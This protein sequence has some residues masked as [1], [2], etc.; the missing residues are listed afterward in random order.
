MIKVFVTG[1]GGTVGI[2]VIKALNLEREKFKIIASDM[3]PASAGLYFKKIFLID[4][5]YCVPPVIDK[6]YLSLL[7]NI[8]E[9]EKIDIIIPTSPPE[10]LFFAKNEDSFSSRGIKIAAPNKE[11]IYKLSDKW[12]S[13][14]LLN[15][16]GIPTPYS[17]LPENISSFNR[18][19][20][21]L[22]VKPRFGDSSKGV[23]LVYS[24]QELSFAI[25][26][27]NNPLIQEYILG[28]EFTV[29]SLTDLTGE[30][31]GILPMKRE[32]MGGS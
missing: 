22:V 31:I 5:S 11:I 16:L 2:G 3:N 14:Q 6:N 29:G 28:P 25:H 15:S 20:Y 4:N 21:P 30:V 7:N 12:S 27:T 9:A 26:H 23:R 32:L 8:L 18:V 10:I 17:F 19:S 24:E 13:Y 1:V